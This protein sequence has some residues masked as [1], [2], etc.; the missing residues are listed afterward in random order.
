MKSLTTTLS[1]LCT[2]SL[3]TAQAPAA[4]AKELAKL[5][6]M[7]GH[8]EGSG[9]AVMAKGAPAMEWTSRSMI[10]KVMDGHFLREDVV[11]D[12][13]PALPAVLE[14]TSFYGWDRDSKS[15]QQ[16][17]VGNTGMIVKQPMYLMPDG[18]FVTA[19]TEVQEGVPVNSRWVAKYN[20]DGTGS[21]YSHQCNGGGEFYEHVV[22]TSKRVDAVEASMR[23]GG[24]FMVPPPGDEM[25]RLNRMAGTYDVKGK[26]LAD[27]SQ[28]MMDIWGTN[29]ATP[30]FG[31]TVL[32][33]TTVGNPGNYKAW[34]AIAWNGNTGEYDQVYVN[35]MGEIGMAKG[36]W[37]GDDFVI[38]MS[39]RIEGQPAAM[40]G[41]SHCDAKGRVTSVTTH[42]IFG[43][44]EPLKYFSA[45]YVHSALEDK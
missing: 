6:A 29:T 8:W 27:P 16:I 26:M 7:I 25:Q 22:G 10:R 35:S 18:S 37:V 20:K 21:M 11:I 36:N 33:M 40:R 41:I 5:E 24:S 34:T 38:T 44:Q 39:S 12:F 30:I 23:S 42:G 31:G 45:D 19:G 3:A 1:V 9:T 15:Y 17:S 28:P 4:P 43:N 13:G 14:F 2:L 32:E